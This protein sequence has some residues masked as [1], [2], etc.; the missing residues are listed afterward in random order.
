MRVILTAA[1]ALAVIMV[2]G[3]D[4]NTG[5]AKTAKVECNCAGTPPAGMRPS[6]AYA[7]PA[8]PYHH[9]WHREHHGTG[10]AS[11]HGGGSHSY[12][13][14]REYAELSVATYDY[15]STS[16]SYY[17]SGGDGGGSSG[18]SAY[19]YA[20]AYSGGS[21][22]AGAGAHGGDSYDHHGDGHYD[23][24]GDGYHAVPHGWVDGYGRG[25]DGGDA[26]T[27]DPAHYETHGDG[28]HRGDPWHGYDIDCPD[29]ALH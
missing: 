25:H 28:P 16:H 18:A 13:W 14:R 2:S 4:I 19:A 12:Y 9:R 15:H 26:Y 8:E 1:A 6:T 11:W 21:A 20:G 3:C 24:H 22:Y 10:T 29:D 7:P 23:R 17:M 5:P 27:G